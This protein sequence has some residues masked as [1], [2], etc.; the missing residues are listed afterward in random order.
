MAPTNR[1]LMLLGL[2]AVAAAF[3][4][5][6]FSWAVTPRFVHCGPDYKVPEPG[7]PPR[8]PLSEVYQ[9]MSTFPMAT[10]EKFTLQTEAPANVHEELKILEAARHNKAFNTSTKVIHISA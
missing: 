7:K 2:Q 9:K 10:L 5:P 3:D 8:L 1:L 6:D 4:L